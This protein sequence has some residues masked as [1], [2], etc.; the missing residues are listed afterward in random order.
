MHPLR[1]F[2]PSYLRLVFRQLITTQTVEQL[3]EVRLP[4]R[5]G[6]DPRPQLP[7]R[8][9]PHMLPMSACEIGNPVALLVPVKADDR[10]FYHHCWR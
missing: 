1:K 9:V 3:A 7:R 5:V 6:R 4:S 2:V 8:T 10:L